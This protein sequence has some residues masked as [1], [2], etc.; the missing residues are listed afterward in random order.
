M[1]FLYILYLL[2]RPISWLIIAAFIAIAAAGPVN[3]LQRKMKRGFAI[4]LVYIGLVLIPFG[5]GALLIPPLVSEIEELA[6]NAPEYVT[7]VEDYVNENKTLNNL[8]DDYDIT[9]KLQEEA[10]KL[11][12]KIPDAAGV[13]SDIGV[14]LVNSIFAG[15]DDPDPEHLHG[16]RRAP[17][18]P[19][20]SSRPSA[21]ST[22]SA[23]SGRCSESRTRSATTS[24]AR[25]CRRP[26]PA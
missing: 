18:G 26:S 22:P 9:T 20:A 24:A 6:A 7:D 21:P 5:L 15:R 4:A 16:G 12:E 11:P 23:S 3:V 10:E 13:L 14:G 19:V 2:R 1:L 25:C 8:N 17:V